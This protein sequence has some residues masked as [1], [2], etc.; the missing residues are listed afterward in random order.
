MYR[1]LR[2]I[3][4]PGEP[5]EGAASVLNTHR[6]VCGE[7]LGVRQRRN[8]I[9]GLK[10]ARIPGDFQCKADFGRQEIDSMWQK[11]GMRTRLL[12][13]FGFVALVAATSAVYSVLTIRHLRAQMHEEIVG[14][15]A[16]LDQARQVTL[17]I[18]NM[19]MAMRGISLFSMMHA[20]EPFNKARAAFDEAAAE[21]RKTVQEMASGNIG[22]EE[23]ASVNAIRSSLD[24]WVANFQEFADMAAAGHG[25][26][27]SQMTLKKTSPLMDAAQKGAADFG[28]ANSAR[29]DAAIDAAESAIRRNE[30][31][32]YLFL[33]LVLLASVGG[34][35]VVTG[36]AKTLKEISESVA[37]GAHQVA[38]AAGQVSS[39]SQTLAQSS[40]E[41]AASLEETS[42][43]AEEITSMARRNTENSQ[44]AAGIVGHSEEK[45]RETNA[46]LGEMVVAMGEIN[47]SSQK[48]SK[49]IKVIDEIAFQTNIL[50]LNAAVEAARAGEAGMGFAVVADE[51]RNLAQRCAQAAKDTSALIE[52]SIA[53]S[54]SGKSKVDRVAQALRGVT[55]EATQVKTLVDEVSVGSQ[56]Q[57]RGLDQISQAIA[58]MDKVGQSTAATA[59]ESAAAAEELNAQSATL[60]DL[61]QQL[62]GLVEGGHNS[63]HVDEGARRVA[64]PVS[65]SFSE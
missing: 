47:G 24:P 18:A 46:A 56:E 42:A 62:R 4:K 23:R 50:A 65:S 54:D 55:E 51:V 61:A 28:K 29:R 44:N 10:S 45:F 27:A 2:K 49:I 39:S 38:Q 1:L 31:L 59:E 19:R 40:S 32:T 7:C 11:I 17:G 41:N 21:A 53:K 35:F 58:Q 64:I 63:G 30:L 5:V 6:T 14:S 3:A 12:V 15:A 43:S 8:E 26:E 48:I 22:A 34:F 9:Q 60:T 33:S 37:I 36:L 13:G 57:A 52:E 20:Q 16:R 25:E